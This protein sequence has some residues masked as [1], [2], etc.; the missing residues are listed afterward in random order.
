MAAIDHLHGV[1][2][3]LHTVTIRDTIVNRGWNHRIK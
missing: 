1:Q 2:M 3:P